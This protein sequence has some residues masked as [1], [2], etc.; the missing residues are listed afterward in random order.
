MITIRKLL[1]TNRFESQLLLPP[2][3]DPTVDVRVVRCVNSGKVQTSRELTE[4]HCEII[5]CIVT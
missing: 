3:L 5:T 2:D 4:Y 1:F